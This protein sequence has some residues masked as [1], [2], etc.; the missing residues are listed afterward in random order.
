VCQHYACPLDVSTLFFKVFFIT[1]LLNREHA[2]DT[3]IKNQGL[4]ERV[5]ARAFFY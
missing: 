5:A 2:L 4:G 1:Y 3:S